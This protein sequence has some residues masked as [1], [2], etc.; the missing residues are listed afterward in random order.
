MTCGGLPLIV[1]M[2]GQKTHSA[3]GCAAGGFS[4]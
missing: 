3:W 4:A 2:R 1:A